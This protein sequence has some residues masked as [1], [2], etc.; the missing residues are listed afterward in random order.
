[1]ALADHEP[2]VRHVEI[3]MQRRAFGVL[4]AMDRPQDL[5]AVGQRH[6]LERRASGVIGRERNVSAR[7]PVLRQHD[8]RELAGQPVDDRHD[9]IAA[10][11]RKRAARHE[12]V[13]NVD[14][15]KDFVC[16]FHHRPWLI[17]FKR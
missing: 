15:Q 17:A 1:M 8:M 13:L 10:R 16:A 6:G 3:A 5:F 4:H 9:L 2:R 11:N 7:M 14:C 12:I